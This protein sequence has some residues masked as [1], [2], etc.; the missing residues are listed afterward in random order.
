MEVSSTITGKRAEYRSPD[1]GR[2]AGVVLG[3]FGHP[4]LFSQWNWKQDYQ[5][6]EMLRE[7]ILESLKRGYEMVVYESMKDDV[8][9][10]WKSQRVKGVG[11]GA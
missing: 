11:N 7:E 10:V 3:S 8:K 2:W 5:L 9:I 4:S 1:P 6:R